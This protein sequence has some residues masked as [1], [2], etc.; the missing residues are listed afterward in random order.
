MLSHREAVTAKPQIAAL[1]E[2]P[3]V[4]VDIDVH[5]DSGKVVFSVAP[6]PGVEVDPLDP[7][8]LIVHPG[9]YFLEFNAVTD[10]F[11][12]PALILR[13]PFGLMGVPPSS[14]T[15]VTLPNDNTLQLG[16][17]SDQTYHF[18]FNFA[19]GPLDPAIINTPDPA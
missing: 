4:H 13:T 11:K 1:Q 18:T 3:A 12:N 16:E 19:S 7:G 14:A 10:S 15:R 5:I 2:E 9:S 6:N 8:N 17:D